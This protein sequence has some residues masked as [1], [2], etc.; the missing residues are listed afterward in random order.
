[1][2]LMIKLIKMEGCPFCNEMI[3]GLEKERISFEVIDADNNEGFMLK[4]NNVLNKDGLNLPIIIINK[5]VLIAS[6]TFK[7]ISEGIE[8]VKYIIKNP[9]I[10]S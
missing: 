4:L 1:M 10:V 5:K 8:M 2:D 7:T 6:E 9:E 3:V